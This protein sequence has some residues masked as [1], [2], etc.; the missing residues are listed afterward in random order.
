MADENIIY[1]E[2]TAKRLLNDF[3]ILP[4]DKRRKACYNCIKIDNA[5]D[6]G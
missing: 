3:F 2:Q 1:F 4:L 5:V 6:T